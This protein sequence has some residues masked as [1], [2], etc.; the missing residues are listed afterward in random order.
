MASCL[1]VAVMTRLCS[2]GKSALASAS[3]PYMVTA[4]GYGLSPLALMASCLPV[5]VRIRLCDYA[6]SVLVE[7]LQPYMVIPIGYGLSPLAMMVSLS[8]IHIS[9]P[10]R[11]GM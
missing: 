2:C 3:Q 11:L 4:K 5:A 7:T 1:P 10:T 6:R 9:E 8:L